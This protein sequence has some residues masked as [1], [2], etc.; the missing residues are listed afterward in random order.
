MEQM[1]DAGLQN[2]YYWKTKKKLA[3]LSVITIK[4]SFLIEDV[5]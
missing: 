4:V 3:F 2:R 1:F 5:K